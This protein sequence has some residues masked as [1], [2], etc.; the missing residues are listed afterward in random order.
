MTDSAAGGNAGGHDYADPPP[1]RT[2][3]GPILFLTA[4]FFLNF[5][6]RIIPSPLM[7]TIESDLRL[8]HG[9][10]GA[11]FL[12]TAAG[13]FVTLTGSGYVSSRLQHRRTIIVSAVAVGLALLSISL[14]RSL[15]S[16]R[17][18]LLGLGMAAGLYL[19][20]AIASLTSLVG[21]RHWGKAIAIHE[22]APNLGFVLAPLLTEVLLAW[23][24]WRGILSLVGAASLLT[25]IAYALFGRGGDFPGE[26]PAFKSLRPLVAEPSF[27]IMM[28]LFSLGISSTVGIYSMLP[29]Y[30]V[31][32]RGLEQ[33]TAN[34]LVAISRVL[35]LAMALLSGWATDR[36]GPRPT[37]MAG[38]L[39]T[40]I[41][42]V[43]IAVVPISMIPSIVIAQAMPAVCFF[44]AGFAALSYIG[45]PGSRSIIVS[46]TIPV[47][48]LAGAGLMPTLIGMMGDAGSFGLGFGLVGGM[49]ITGG[50]LS[51]FLRLSRGHKS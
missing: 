51:R 23:V 27:W 17:L 39:L 5:I 33:N 30:L 10:A 1:F 19:P 24:S 26:S 7:P 21:P 41:L 46:F 45:P 6:S 29:L 28:V 13:Y 50:L 14:G 2:Q 31:A 15:W 18:G 4:I 11:L 48:F 49:I 22:L 25:G 36:F 44:P 32:E 9:E 34:T 47:G 20:S 38:L 3:L 42:T 12:L 43:L 16:L 8:N 40:G 35:S 37:M